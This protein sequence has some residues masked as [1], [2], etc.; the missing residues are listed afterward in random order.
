MSER[1]LEPHE[2]Q[3][4]LAAA[5]AYRNHEK[6][7]STIMGQLSKEGVSRTQLVAVIGFD[8]D[9]SASPS[10]GPALRKLPFF[11]PQGR[12]YSTLKGRETST[13]QIE[14][15]WQRPREFVL[16]EFDPDSVVVPP[17]PSI[18]AV[19]G[20]ST[21]DR[22]SREVNRIRSAVQ[23][24]AE[25]NQLTWASVQDVTDAIARLK[26]RVLHLAGHNVSGG[27]RLAW[28]TSDVLV[29]LEKLAS[30]FTPA[31]RHTLVVL[32]ICDSQPQ[33][34]HFANA[35]G[36]VMSWPCKFDD[37][38]AVEFATQF[39]SHLARGKRIDEACESAHGHTVLRW[40]DVANPNC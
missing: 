40:D 29:R 21:D 32:S 2:I 23:G 4:L 36:S 14:A 8:P 7:L 6:R 3:L 30:V 33:A 1:Q 12:T 11:N 19:S 16:Q 35:F 38:Y 17:L 5:R 22:W 26:P 18:L 37:D 10:P 34:R 9:H 39:Y 13:T 27:I 31:D 28:G 24:V 15:V 20:P 25:T